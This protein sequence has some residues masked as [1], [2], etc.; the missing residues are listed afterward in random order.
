MSG[1][2][3]QITFPFAY[4]CACKLKP[5]EP[6]LELWAAVVANAEELKGWNISD[7]PQTVIET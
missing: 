2:D 4:P 3:I 7:I 1:A 5:E 6:N